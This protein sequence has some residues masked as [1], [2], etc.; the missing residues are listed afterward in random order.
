MAQT[1]VTAMR[2]ISLYS[3]AGRITAAAIREE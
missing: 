1:P 2:K 3:H